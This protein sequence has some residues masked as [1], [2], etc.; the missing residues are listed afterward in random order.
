MG[1]W[2][3]VYM[4]L[5]AVVMAAA[6]YRKDRDYIWIS[7]LMV[8]SQIN[9]RLILLADEQT[10]PV[11]DFLSDVVICCVLIHFFS[12]MLVSRV[13]MILFAC[14]SIFAYLPRSFELY[15]HDTYFV[16]I[17]V[18]SFTML[19]VILGGIS[20]GSRVVGPNHENRLG[21][22]R[23]NIRSIFNTVFKFQKFQKVHK[24]DDQLSERKS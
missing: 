13:L 20:S 22:R 16:V 1:L 21:H 9:C 14:L 17:D 11:L 15:S 19:F 18:I 12:E 24:R 7:A 6:F 5:L 10:Q 4:T 8:M 2:G 3:W 23:I